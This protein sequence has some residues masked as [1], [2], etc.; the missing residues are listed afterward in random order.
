MTTIETDAYRCSAGKYMRMLAGI[1]LWRWWWALM[2]P[3]CVLFYL[4]VTVNVA[5]AYVALMLIFI[6]FP[7]LVMFM[8]LT[9]VT[10]PEAIVATQLKT[11]SFNNNGIC[12]NFVKVDTEENSLQIYKSICFEWSEF[13][14]FEQSGGGITLYKKNNRYRLLYIPYSAISGKEKSKELILLLD[15]KLARC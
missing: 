2:L 13:D 7:T 9:Q 8:F 14:R 10:T 1:W 11:L 4:A 6:V 15:A 3:L 5:W 12:V